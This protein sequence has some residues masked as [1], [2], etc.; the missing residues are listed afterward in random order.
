MKKYAFRKEPG[1][2]YDETKRA[3]ATRRGLVIYLVVAYV[4][5][6]LYSIVTNKLAG[7]NA[8][9]WTQVIIACVGIGGAAVAAVVLATLRMGR[10]LAESEIDEAEETGDM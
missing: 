5:Y 2:K 6:L 8:M 1:K 7:T 3:T 9:S 4:I 10:E